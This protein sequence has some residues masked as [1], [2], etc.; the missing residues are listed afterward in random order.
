MPFT[1]S[2]LAHSYSIRERFIEKKK[3][4]TDKC[5]FCPYTYL[6]TVKTDIFLFFFHLRLTPTYLKLTFVSFSSFFL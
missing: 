4:K 3:K 5:L 6:R 2:L 1:I